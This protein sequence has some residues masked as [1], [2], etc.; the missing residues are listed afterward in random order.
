MA[1][2]PIVGG[3]GAGTNVSSNA[4]VSLYRYITKQ[5]PRVLTIYDINMEPKIARS[6]IQ[7][8]FRTNGHVQDPRV[9]DML[10]TKGHMEVE[11]TLMQWKQKTHLLSLIESGLVKEKEVM[12]SGDRSLQ[13][14]FSDMDDDEDDEMEDFFTDEAFKEFQD[15]YGYEN[16][17]QKDT[18]EVKMLPNVYPLYESGRDSGEK[19]SLEDARKVLMAQNDM[20]PDRET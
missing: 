20:E 9:L 16:E 11:E 12:S 18:E 8:L 17:V 5:I 1:L 14:F 4:V 13:N 2:R 7:T 10:V 6:A 3:G 15:K 19:L